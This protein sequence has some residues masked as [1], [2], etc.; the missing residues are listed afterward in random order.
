M[1]AGK[2]VP[3][4]ALFP[5]YRALQ[6]L[7]GAD[8]VHPADLWRDDWAWQELG[9][10]CQA[11][12]MQADAG[13]ALGH[14]NARCWRSCAAPTARRCS[15]LSDLCAGLGAASQRHAWPACGSCRPRSSRRRRTGLLQPDVYAKRVSSRLLAQLR[16]S[17]ARADR[18]LRP[19][20]PGPAVL[21]RA[22]ARARRRAPG[23]AARS[24]ARGLR[25][26]CRRGLRLPGRASGSLRPGLDRAGTQARGRR[27]GSVVGGGRRR[28]ASPERPGRAVRA[29]RRFAEAA[30]SVGRGAGRGAAGG[31]QPD[32]GSGAD[33]AGRAGDGSGHQPALP[34][35]LAR[36]RRLRPP[37]DRQARAAPG[38]AHPR[39]ARGPRGPAARAVDGGAVP[40]RVATARPWAAWCRNCACRCPRSKSRSTS[41]SATRR[42]ARC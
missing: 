19:P 10:G 32:R 30:V 13:R 41:T 1:L 4:L 21:L 34:G 7:A 14:G 26:R 23:A 20:G 38:A 27:Q 16:L 25:P 28:G 33:A 22:G 31:R 5:Q 15:A 35:R 40:A 24:R 8:R 9:A 2:G 12:P 3:T 18:G 6:E 37:A 11:A 17:I 29:G 39:R 42:S 36:G